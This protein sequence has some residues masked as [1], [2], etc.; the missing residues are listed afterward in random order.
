MPSSPN[1]A[2]ARVRREL[3]AGRATP[4]SGA[5]RPPTRDAGCER[6]RSWNWIGND[7]LLL[8]TRGRQ[9]VLDD[10]GVDAQALEVTVTAKDPGAAFE[11]QDQ[12]GVIAD[13]VI[14]LGVVHQK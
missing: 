3:T 7:P 5:R 13:R 11:A 8:E 12:A 10:G 9:P 2:R 6:S 4:V 1:R 14:G